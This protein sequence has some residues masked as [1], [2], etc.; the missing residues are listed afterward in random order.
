MG[1]IKDKIEGKARELKG[2]VTN[3]KAEEAHGNAQQ[4]KGKAEGA[5]NRAADKMGSEA[6]RAKDNERV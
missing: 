2:K 4:M 5:V 6:N 1:E 3:D